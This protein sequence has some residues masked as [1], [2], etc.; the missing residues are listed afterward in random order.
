MIKSTFSRN[1]SKLPPSCSAK[2][3]SLASLAQKLQ[4]VDINSKASTECTLPNETPSY[5]VVPNSFTDDGSKVLTNIGNFTRTSLLV[6]D[7]EDFC[8]NVDR[9]VSEN[10]AQVESVTSSQQI[11]GCGVDNSVA[12]CISEQDGSEN[13]CDVSLSGSWDD[14]SAEFDRLHLNPAT[15][16]YCRSARPTPFGLTLSAVPSAVKRA[17]HTQQKKAGLRA[18]FSYFRQSDAVARARQRHYRSN[19]Q[20]LMSFDFSTPSPDD[21]IQEKQKLAFGEHALR[22]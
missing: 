6:H 19:T 12:R 3:L 16:I 20:P 14:S 1:V 22:K 2:K 18:R 9:S 13:T 7:K 11:C 17:G 5:P 4:D 15:E 8:S 10:A 21:I